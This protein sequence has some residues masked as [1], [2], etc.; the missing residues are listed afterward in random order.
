MSK[1]VIGDSEG[2]HLKLDIELLIPSR[3]LIQ[4]N[5]GGGKSW[6]LRRLAEQ[7]FGKVQTI[8]LDPEGEFF[9]LRE[10]FGYVLVGE[11]GETPADIRSAA[12]L[13]EKFLQLKASAVCDLYEAFRSRPMDR[14]QW[15]RAFLN[16]LLDAP[17]TLW[18][19]LIVIVDEA[20]KFCPQETPKAASMQDREVI[21]G[22]KDAMI[23]LS[24]TGRKRGFCPIWATQ[25]LA[26]LDK[27]ASA[28][29]FNRLVGMTIEDVDVDRA[30]DLMSVSKDEKH[31]FRSSLRS[32][33]PGDFYAFGRAITTE[34]KLVKVGDV[35]THHPETGKA[36]K[37]AEPPP[38]PEEVKGLLPQLADLPQQAEEKARTEAEFKKEIR[39]LRAQLKQ[40]EKLQPKTATPTAGKPDPQQARLLREFRALLGEAMKI[41]AKVN[42]IGF[43]GSA[44]NPDEI[45]GALER[46]ASEIAR[47]AGN[48][49]EAQQKEFERTKTEMNRLMAKLQRHLSEE[50]VSVAVDVTKNEPVTVRS[51]SRPVQPINRERLQPSGDGSTN[52]DLQRGERAVLIAIAQFGTVERDQLTVLTGYKRSSR[53]TYIQRLGAK[54]Y[55]ESEGR[56]SVR[57]TQAGVDALGSDYEPLPTG[58]ELQ[59]YWLGRLPEGERRVFEF[60]LQHDGPVEKD[61]IDEA[62]GY[63]RS[64]RDTYLQRLGARCLVESVGRG[65]VQLARTVTEAA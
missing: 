59:E 4:A 27:D 56:G 43:D 34:R 51:S 6:L 22:C 60:L 42:A 11:G 16:A 57:I 47:L 45:K 7:L 26:K 15:V 61:A 5:S 19:P 54:G 49:L 39:E 41:I 35:Q 32:L 40:A 52:G 10:K 64:S 18:H 63:K 2:K 21:G 50:E 29:F 8:I 13:A 33:N 24:T 31:D 17:R 58:R 38:M 25:R 48:K 65:Q 46:A 44:V 23:A 36:A 62:I 20:H 30:A 12:M 14:R 53:D 37:N 3:L 1:I 28:E 55:V 9:T